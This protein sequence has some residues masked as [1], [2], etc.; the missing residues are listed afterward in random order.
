MNEDI[1]KIFWV[2]SYPKSGNTWLRAFLTSYLYTVDGEFNNFEILDKIIRF[3]SSRFFSTIVN[4]EDIINNPDKISKY[5]IKVQNEI[6]SNTEEYVFV[7]THNFCG[8]INK[9]PFTSSKYTKGFIYLVRDPRAVAVSFANHTKESIDGVI[10]SMLSENPKYVSNSGAYPSFYF[11][12]KINYFS[13]KQFKNIVPGLI[14]RYED[15]F[16]TESFFKITKFLD[17]LNIYTSDTIKAM[18]SIKSTSFRK[19][20]ELENKFGFE[21]AGTNKFFY[22]GKKNNWKNI[23]NKNQLEKIEKSLSLEMKELE[24]I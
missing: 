18:T 14:I 21:E 2:A 7:K 4:H 17:D 6:V 3:E 16:N 13:W 10:E 20:N 1:N 23:L 24:Y 8:S 12:W 22:K 9:N 19:L 11:N 5:W 15:L